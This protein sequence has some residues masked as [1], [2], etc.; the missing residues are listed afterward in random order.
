MVGLAID[1]YVHCGGVF[2]VSRLWY[3]VELG[4]TMSSDVIDNANDLAAQLTDAY[5]AHAR[6]QNRPLPH[7]G[8]CYNCTEPITQAQG[9]FCDAECRDDWQKRTDAQRRN[10]GATQTKP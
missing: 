8:E 4:G 7:T 1:D 9:N 6:A 2:G 10:N 5:V 3:F